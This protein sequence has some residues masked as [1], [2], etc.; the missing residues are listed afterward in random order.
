MFQKAFAVLFISFSFIVAATNTLVIQPGPGEAEDCQVSFDRELLTGG[1]WPNYNNGSTPCFAVGA[2]DWNTVCRALIKFNMPTIDPDSI[3][4]AKMVLFLDH[5]Q[6]QNLDTLYKIEIYQMLRSWK[7]GTG[8]GGCTDKVP[9]SAVIDGATG[10][11]RFWG[12]QDGREDWNVP[13]VG[14]DDVDAM[15]NPETSISQ[16]Y[17]DSQWEF[18]I[19]NLCKNWISGA[20]ENYG[21]L[22]CSPYEHGIN[23]KT[24][25]YPI[26]SSGNNT[27]DISKR[28]KLL[29]TYK[30]SK[31]T[32]AYWSFDENSGTG[33]N[34]ETGNGNDGTI[35]GGPAWE[36]GVSGSCLHFDGVNDYV[37]IPHLPMQSNMSKLTIEAWIKPDKWLTNSNI[38]ISKWGAGSSIDDVYALSSDE[39][40]MSRPKHALFR[41][42]GTVNNVSGDIFSP[43]TMKLNTWSHIVSIWTGDS[44]KLY[45]NGE[46][47]A[48]HSCTVTSL[49]PI[50]IPLMIGRT[51]HNEGFASGC[52]DEITMYNYEVDSSTIALRY[53]TLKPSITQPTII[54]EWSFDS[55]YQKIFYDITKNGYDA[56]STGLGVTDG[57]NGMALECKSS[58]FDVA[59]SNSVGNFQLE[60]FTIEGW[61]YPYVDMINP[62]SFY[63]FKQ[64]FDYCYVGLEGSGDAGGYSMHI[65]DKGKLEL[66]L[67]NPTKVE[68]WES[69]Q[70]DSVIQPR[71][72]YHIAASYD[73][74]SLKLFIN[75]ELAKEQAYTLGYLPSSIPARIGCQHQ[76]ISK[77]DSHMRNWF[78]G[79]M[80]EFRLYNYALDPQTLASHYA[81]L[82]PPVE[83]SFE[84]NLGMKTTYAEP[85]D[86]VTMPVFITNFEDFSISA[87]Q[88]VMNFDTSRLQFID[89]SKDS[90]KFI[91]DWPLFNWHQSGSN[92]T[93]AMGGAQTPISYG[94][95]ELIRSRFLVKP[96]VSKSDSCIIVLDHI[97]IDES[98]NMVKA[99]S[100]NGKI[101][102]GDFSILYGDITGNNDVNIFD[103]QK[104]LAYVV[105]SISLPDSVCCPNFTVAV[106]DV[107]GN[108]SITSYDAALIFQYSVGM[109]QEFPVERRALQKKAGQSV[110]ATLS[111][112]EENDGIHGVNYR[113]VGSGLKGFRAGEFS[114]KYDPKAINLSKGS[115]T[116]T[117]RGAT[118]N[119]KLDSET[120]L[121]RIALATNDDIDNNDIVTLATITAPPASGSASA[122]SILAALIN[123][124][125]I[126][127]NISDQALSTP[128]LN[129]T[130][131]VSP[132][133]VTFSGRNLIISH[134]GSET[135]DLRIWGLDGRCITRKRLSK[136]YTVLNLHY[137]K[138][139][140]LYQIRFGSKLSTGRF[141]I[142]N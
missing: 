59:I 66:S 38:V 97:I 125:K 116:T 96:S 134:I 67:A 81:S 31:K 101:I 73:G 99:T 111:M 23:D 4:S 129:S 16:R 108:G 61:I 30:S 130:I 110:S 39:F 109:L 63:N 46:L 48:K 62:G 32:I 45:I 123:E 131:K 24:V 1:A 54:A 18:D 58:D 53:N 121:L 80:D 26:F 19:T 98:F 27:V 100:N 119:S 6:K 5:Y 133:S 13:N 42:R 69:I 70:S 43:D 83:T 15:S 57:V 51:G 72:W 12:N 8:S 139:I 50:E 20:A 71:K 124:G 95:G 9:N 47:K 64:I 84:I 77:T 56:V 14:L 68:P 33:L 113:L 7:A 118:L 82:K 28:P 126:V 49:N 29:I 127:S 92:I 22:I 11:D 78:N 138:G 44:I 141:I 114:I 90:S 10:L 17:T 21:I 120:N 86:T 137:V 135:I 103:A 36:N 65:T 37:E 107:S 76:V 41:V 115:I 142:S 88:F 106:A 104:V 128:N 40:P 112:T 102:I 60:N 3:I 75:G 140:Y 35:Y 87:C 105:G 94:E 136:N 34:D 89:I 2:Y 132:Y 93:I 52:I 55:T 85:G 79:K 117:I 74:S 25:S 91:M 122:L